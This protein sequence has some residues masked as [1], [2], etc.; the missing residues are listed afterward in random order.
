MNKG[1]QTMSTEPSGNVKNPLEKD[2]GKHKSWSE[3]N[4]G[5][6]FLLLVSGII[7]LVII[8]EFFAQ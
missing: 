5:L 7:G 4:G 8:Y 3:R 6:V 2:A 1:D